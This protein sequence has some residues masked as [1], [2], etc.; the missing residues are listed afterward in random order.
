MSLLDLPDE[1]ITNVIS[2][3]DIHSSCALGLT[4]SRLDRLTRPRLE[5]LKLERVPPY[6]LKYLDVRG[7]LVRA[8]DLSGCDAN[9]FEIESVIAKCRHVENINVLGSERLHLNV[10][11]S[12]D[13][14]QT[15]QM[16]ALRPGSGEFGRFSSLRK[17]F[18]KS[19]C[20]SE[21]RRFSINFLNTCDALEVIHIE[22]RGPQLGSGSSWLPD[23][24]AGRWAT[25]HTVVC[26]NREEWPTM[27]YALRFLEKIFAGRS[28]P[29]LHTWM[30]QQ[31]QCYIYEHGHIN[32]EFLGD[33]VIDSNVKLLRDFH[34]P[35]VP[36][37]GELNWAQILSEPQPEWQP[38]W[39]PE[40]VRNFKSPWGSPRAVRV[41]SFYGVLT[42]LSDCLS[43]RL[44]ELDLTGCHGK[45]TQIFRLNL[46]SSSPSLE[47]FACTR[48]LFIPSGAE[49]SIALLHT[50][51][52]AQALGTL[53]L[54]K[55]FVGGVCHPG[56]AWR[57]VPAVPI[58]G[59]VETS[60]PCHVTTWL[61]W[62]TS[63]ISTS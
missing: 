15:L 54:K 38:E 45:F 34:F 61:L 4:T 16:S 14:L 35:G 36:Y 6:V 58:A 39:Q 60:R 48:C 42:G 28:L 5:T 12:L 29:G 57:R 20:S 24:D 26:F 7:S 47:H 22:F 33:A 55:L 21:A 1:V 37:F 19:R 3:M 2:L 25:L 32:G 62:M 11:Y 31:K 46:I 63:S 27:Y 53:K 18:I 43:A 23:F 40:P 9:T 50:E 59:L 49:G 17:I 51:D 56:I 8:L 52:F 13:K 10:L 30:R 44:K 41:D